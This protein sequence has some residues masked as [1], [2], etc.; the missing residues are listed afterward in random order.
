[1]DKFRILAYHRIGIPRGGRYERLTVLPRRF[2]R[3]LGVMRRLRFEFA[4]LDAVRPWLE[5]N[6]KRLRRPVALSFDDGYRDLFEHAFPLLQRHRIPATVF[7][8][9][10]RER[11]DWIDRED[12]RPLDLL[13][14]SQV[15]TMSAAGID[16]GSHSLSH[17]PLTDCSDAELRA[18]VTDSKKIIEDHIGREV[19]HFC[20]PYGR[21]DQRVEAAVRSAGYDSACTTQKGVVRQGANPWRLP[22]L[23]VG[24]RM[25]LYRFLAR[26]MFRH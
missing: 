18:E 9:A 14:W 15:K 25:G 7:L 1:M 17:A 11:N 10:R 20:Y 19:R 23:S 2:S 8:V 24:K 22:R 26:F 21:C 16:F 13:S 12:S 3:Q 6:E 4:A 5:E